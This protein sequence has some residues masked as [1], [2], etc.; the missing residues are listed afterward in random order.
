MPQMDGYETMKQI[1]DD[2]KFR[3]LPIIALTAKAMR[4]TAKMPRSRRVRLHCQ[5]GEHGTAFLLRMW[6]YR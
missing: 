5:A 4:A 2:P 6:L 1:R 3:T